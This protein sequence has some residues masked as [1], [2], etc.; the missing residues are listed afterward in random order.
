VQLSTQKIC[1]FSGNPLS[2]IM[3]I[4]LT[5]CVPLSILGE[6]EKKKEGLRPSK[7]SPF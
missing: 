1:D 7:Y 6:G 4:N 5:P 3:L 2:T